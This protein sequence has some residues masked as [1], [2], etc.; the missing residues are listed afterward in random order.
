MGV[1]KPKAVILKASGTNCDI[2][3]RDA[4]ALVGFDAEIVH[5]NEIISGKKKILDY[6]TIAIP[7]GFSYGDDISAGK[8]FAIRIRA[9]KEDFKRF[10]E[11]KRPVIGICNGFQV[12]VKT[13]FLP[14]DADYKQKATLY[15][16]D[17]G[18]F[19]CR[20]VGVRVNKYS[21]CI[22]TKGID[23]DFYLPVAHGEGKFIA[24]SNVIKYIIKNNMDSLRYIENPNGS[25][26]NIAGITNQYGN[27]FGLMPHPER[28]IFGVLKPGF[29]HKKYYIGYE[30]F[31]N[32]R[33]Y[34]SS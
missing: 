21:P 1:K 12:L 5:I 7:G 13:G 19:V 27:L 26:Y 25:F 9:L 31:R 4:F 16:N 34:I 24:A 11:D 28:A 30:F 20:W 29:Y 17:V 6:D 2:E 14:Y 32:A 15:L 18:H 3:T 33:K 8:I 23:C 22:W 10:I